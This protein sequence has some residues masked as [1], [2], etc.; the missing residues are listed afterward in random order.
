MQLVVNTAESCGRT[1]N[2]WK[3]RYWQAPEVEGK[4]K[5]ERAKHGKIGRGPAL[6]LTSFPFYGLP[7]RL[8]A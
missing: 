4:K 8:K 1:C 2:L 7:H 3:A 6:I 5:D